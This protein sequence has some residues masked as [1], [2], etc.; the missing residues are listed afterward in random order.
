M[1]RFKSTCFR[2]KVLAT[3]DIANFKIWLLMS[4]QYPTG[5]YTDLLLRNLKNMFTKLH[6]E[7]KNQLLHQ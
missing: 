5:S 7:S 1:I 3:V 2:K 4:S 6:A